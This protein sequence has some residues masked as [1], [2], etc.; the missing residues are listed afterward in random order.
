[1][2]YDKSK[3]YKMLDFECRGMLNFGF[4]EKGLRTVSRSHFMYDFST[5]MFLILY[6]IN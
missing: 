3:L 1:M 2:V 4:L 6:T 5:K